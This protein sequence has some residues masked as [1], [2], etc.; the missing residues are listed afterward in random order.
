MRPGQAFALSPPSPLELSAHFR[1][2]FD[3]CTRANLIG[4]RHANAGKST[5][6]ARWSHAVRPQSRLPVRA[7]R[8]D[9][10]LHV[11]SSRLCRFDTLKTPQLN[12]LR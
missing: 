7:H 1:I 6:R 11:T 10:V 3:A 2:W 4:P 9:F 12:S 8:R 5:Q